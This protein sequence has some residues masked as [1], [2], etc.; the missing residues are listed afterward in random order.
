MNV[1]RRRVLGLIAASTLLAACGK[2]VKL[3]AIAPGKTVLAFGDSVTFGTGA[4]PG[5]DW[6][7]LIAARTGWRVINAG[8][9]GDTAEAGKNRL[10]ALLAE[11]RPEIGR[12][13]V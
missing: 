10:P 9:P 4:A 5:E 2:S 6:P 1:T 7:S 12:A 3:A 11:H 8:V 13:H